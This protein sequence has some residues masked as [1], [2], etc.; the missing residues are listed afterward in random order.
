MPSDNKSL[1]Q[2]AE[3]TQSAA[4]S[5]LGDPVSLKAE[6][7]ASEPTEQD[8][9]NKAAGSEHKS[10][11]ESMQDSLK[12]NPTALGDPVSLKAE[13]SDTEPTEEDRGARGTSKTGQPKS[14][15]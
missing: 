14:K 6:T 12:H 4:P 1:K 9:P 13:T 10:L 11:K 15:I 5:Q 2:V 3:E 7:S 8:K